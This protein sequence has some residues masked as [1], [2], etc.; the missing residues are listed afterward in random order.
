MA[1]TTDNPLRLLNETLIS[2]GEGHKLPNNPKRETIRSWA[3]RGVVSKVTGE[4]VALEC[5][6]IGDRRFT[7]VEAHQRF[8]ERL[9]GTKED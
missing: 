5:V 6:Q 1:Q 4:S 8:L 2:F 3:D 7:S 9:N